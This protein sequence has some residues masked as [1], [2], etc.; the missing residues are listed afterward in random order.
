MGSQVKSKTLYL[1][2]FS[3]GQNSFSS[4]CAFKPEHRAML[5][6]R[7]GRLWLKY[8][9]EHLLKTTR[10]ICCL[11]L[12]FPH[13]FRMWRKRHIFLL[14]F[15][16]LNNHCDLLIMNLSKKRLLDLVLYY[17]KVLEDSRLFLNWSL[18]KYLK[19]ILWNPR[20]LCSSIHVS[21]GYKLW[22]MTSG[23]FRTLIFKSNQIKSMYS[24]NAV[25][26]LLVTIKI[27]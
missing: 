9:N 21:I 7:R 5:G 6:E 18:C 10:A 8:V 2:H 27:L 3:V 13:L 17:L 1:V 14:W 16:W 4:K 19:L 26:V 12:A 15:S 22:F 24:L 20:V 11:V 25:L 23:Y